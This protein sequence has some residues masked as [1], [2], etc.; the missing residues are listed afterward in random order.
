MSRMRG[1]GEQVWEFVVG[2]D[3]RVAIGVVV[4][5]AVTAAVAGAGAAAWWIV[6]VAAV[7]LLAGSL[8]R[9]ARS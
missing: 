3:W 4:A 6:P 1:V 5:L 2:D 8:W 7:T 9:A